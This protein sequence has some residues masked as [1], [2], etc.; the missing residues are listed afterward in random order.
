MGVRG[1]VLLCRRRVGDAHGVDFWTVGLLS[2]KWEVK[3]QRQNPKVCVGHPLIGTSKFTS[4]IK[5]THG[6]DFVD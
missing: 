1:R 5:E 6:F 4:F 3:G 2:K